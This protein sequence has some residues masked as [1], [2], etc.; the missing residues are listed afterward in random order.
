[1]STNYS[2]LKFI[3]L[4]LSSWKNKKKGRKSSQDFFKKGNGGLRYVTL[5]LAG[6]DQIRWVHVTVV[7]NVHARAS[8]QWKTFRQRSGAVSFKCLTFYNEPNCLL[9]IDREPRWLRLLT[10][11]IPIDL[12]LRIL[13]WEYKRQQP[14]E[15]VH[16]SVLCDRQD[17]VLFHCP[18]FS[19]VSWGTHKKSFKHRA[20]RFAPDMLDTRR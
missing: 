1:M 11:C 20:S 15:W 19:F 10:F 5:G 8:L 4:I 12:F 18:C 7:I 2:V 13:I 14:Y 6:C 16:S 9:R 3:A 17:E